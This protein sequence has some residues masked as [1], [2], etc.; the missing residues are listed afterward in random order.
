MTPRII[1]LTT[2]FGLR[3]HFVGV[4]K[5]VILGIHTEARIVD[6]THELPPQDLMAGAFVI[7]AAYRYF[8]RGTIH[9]AV[10]DPGVG[11]L[12]K[13]ILLSIDGHT[14]VGPDNGI[15]TLIRRFHP[16]A[17]IRHVT[18]DHY[19][20]KGEGG[21]TFQGRDLFAAVAA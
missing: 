10:V 17:R 15:F 4:M 8:P 19:F 12:R 18:A 13:P 1:T 16:E 3:D 21:R 20:L 7:H 9:L 14:F 2:D 6:I 11:S 5:G